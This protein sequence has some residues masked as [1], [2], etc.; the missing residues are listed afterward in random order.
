MALC[1]VCSLISFPF[2]VCYLFPINANAFVYT[3]SH[4]AQSQVERL[5]EALSHLP[6]GCRSE[7]GGPQPLPFGYFMLDTCARCYHYMPPMTFKSG[8]RFR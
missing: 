3:F 6:L 2:I 1:I 8:A 4:W 7:R 5:Y